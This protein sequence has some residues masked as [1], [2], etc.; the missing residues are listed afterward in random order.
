MKTIT[1]NQKKLMQEAFTQ[2]FK[3]AQMG[4][5]LEVGFDFIWKGLLETTFSK[6]EWK[7]YIETAKK[8]YHFCFENGY[9]SGKVIHPDISAEVA[10]WNWFK[11]SFA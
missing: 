6:P 8:S 11:V 4:Q 10:F 9:A 1:E 3:T 7:P 2:G 5:E